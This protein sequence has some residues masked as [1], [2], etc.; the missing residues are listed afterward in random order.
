[1]HSES[2]FESFM[3]ESFNPIFF[4]M[5]MILFQYNIY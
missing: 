5:I 4:H 1:M 3:N 2:V